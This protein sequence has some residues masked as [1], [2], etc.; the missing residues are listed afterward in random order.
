MFSNLIM[1]TGYLEEVDFSKSITGKMDKP[2]SMHTISVKPKKK[3]S[4]RQNSKIYKLNLC[5]SYIVFDQYDPYHC[6]IGSAGT[7]RS[8]I[9]AGRT[10]FRG[11]LIV[12]AVLKADDE[13]ITKLGKKNAAK[14]AEDIL[15]AHFDDHWVDGEWYALS[16]EDILTYVRDG[17]YE[18]T[19]IDEDDKKKYE[20][21]VQRM[22]DERVK[23]TNQVNNKITDGMWSGML[24]TLKN[25]KL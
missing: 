8:R 20:P 9:D 11:N 4:T 10:W 5:G 1:N 23:R 15:Q 12:F 22:M 13:T 7:L 25:L 17:Q 24:D 14:K 2:P 21:V 16:R 3:K 19:L 6:K 18:L